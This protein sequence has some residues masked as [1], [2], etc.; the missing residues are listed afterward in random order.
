[1][2]FQEGGGA[3]RWVLQNHGGVQNFVSAHSEVQFLRV[4]EKRKLTNSSWAKHGISLKWIADI[5][6]GSSFHVVLFSFLFVEKLRCLFLSRRNQ[7]RPDIDVIAYCSIFRL[8]DW[9]C[10]M[11]SSLFIG[12]SQHRSHWFF[13]C[14]L[15]LD[16]S[17]V[18]NELLGKIILQEHS[19]H[20]CI[21]A[22]FVQLKVASGACWA[23]PHWWDC[24]CSRYHLS[25]SGKDYSWSRLR[26]FFSL[27]FHCITLVWKIVASHD[28]TWKHGAGRG[29]SFGTGRRAR[30]F[31]KYNLCYLLSQVPSCWYF[32]VYFGVSLDVS[33]SHGPS[34]MLISILLEF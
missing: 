29:E 17:H 5:R 2:F 22:I 14:P 1:M 24:S 30:N 6:L 3:H 27:V 25:S 13:S 34:H 33:L 23:C 16:F 8:G 12:P 18:L 9:L 19:A 7:A 10:V 20:C 15:G 4:H 31:G 26:S 32:F 21:R 28:K 11:I